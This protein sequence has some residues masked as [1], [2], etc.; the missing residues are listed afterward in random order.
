M[1]TLK[2]IFGSNCVS[3]DK[4]LGYY[5][6][7]SY[8]IR[9]LSHK[10]KGLTP[11]KRLRAYCYIQIGNGI[12][13]DSW[14][15]KMSID[16]NIYINLS[17]RGLITHEGYLTNK[18]KKIIREGLLRFRR[19][20]WTACPKYLPRSINVLVPAN[21]LCNLSCVIN[22]RIIIGDYKDDTIHKTNLH[23]LD[24]PRVIRQSENSSRD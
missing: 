21:R 18:R 10:V 12:I 15:Y 2:Y 19:I 4:I 3:L 5:Q 20:A 7:E 23:C 16:T 6:Y 9:H 13:Y 22:V 24:T 11:N 1:T 14:S 8:S 17:F